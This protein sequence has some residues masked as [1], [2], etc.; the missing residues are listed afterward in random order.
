MHTASNVP[1]LRAMRHTIAHGAARLAV[2]ALLGTPLLAHTPA[3][4]PDDAFA[5][6]AWHR[7]LGAHVGIETWNYNISHETMYGGSVGLS[8]GLGKGVALVLSAPLYYIEQRTPDAWLLGFTWGARWRVLGRKRLSLFVEGEVGVSRAEHYAPPTGTRFKYLA[9]GTVGV[10]TSL[11]R[12]THL[13]A[14]VKLV[15]LSNNGLAGRAR[16][17]DIEAVGPR[18]AVL[19]RF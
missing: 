13:L 10:T 1:N 18:I 6:G 14:G 11:R 15:H 2:L 8:Y 17:P 19:T 9:L 16:N 7:E 5:K 12:G 4:E 3:Q